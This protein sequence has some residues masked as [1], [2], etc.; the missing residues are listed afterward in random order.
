ME[1]QPPFLY[2]V[3]PWMRQGCRPVGEA[4]ETSPT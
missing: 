2:A 4:M 3:P 1:Q